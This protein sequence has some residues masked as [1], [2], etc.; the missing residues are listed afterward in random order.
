M[1]CPLCTTTLLNQNGRLSISCQKGFELGRGSVDRTFC[2]LQ[3][4]A[5]SGCKICWDVFGYIKTLP[6]DLKTAGSE[7]WKIAYQLDAEYYRQCEPEV[8]RE[9]GKIG[10]HLRIV[11]DRGQSEE[12]HF[13]LFPLPEWIKPTHIDEIVSEAKEDVS[14]VSWKLRDLARMPDSP[15][16]T[17]DPAVISLAKTWLSKC[18]EDHK[19]CKY[20][21]SEFYP[22]RLLELRNGEPSL[23]ETRDQNLR[24]PYATLS[25]CWGQDDFFTLSEGNLDDLMDTVPVA[26]LPKSFQDAILICKRLDIK[27]LWIDSLCIIQSKEEINNDWLEHA[28]TMADI[29]KN[30]LL[31]ISIDRA[32]NPYEGA[33]AE[34]SPR[35]LD[36]CFALVAT[37]FPENELGYYQICGVLDKFECIE[38]T[39]LSRRAWAFQERYLSPRVLHFGTDRIWWECH[40]VSR[41]EGSTSEDQEIDPDPFFTDNKQMNFLVQKYCSRSLTRPDKDKLVAFAAVAREME[42]AKDDEYVAG[43]FKGEL[44]AALLWSPFQ[45]HTRPAKYQAPSWSWASLNGTDRLHLGPVCH[46]AVAEV[47]EIN[48]KYV[49][50]ENRYGLVSSGSL[51]IKGPMGF[52]LWD[53]PE[54]W[55]GEQIWHSRW[56]DGVLVS[57]IPT[58]HYTGTTLEISCCFD[59]EN[60]RIW[61]KNR[62]C[63]FLL[64]DHMEGLLLAETETKGVYKRIGTGCF[65]ERHRLEDFQER[66]IKLI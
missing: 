45:P 12:R 30:C 53:G 26:K 64:I 51:R 55:G 37:S 44:P 59:T 63:D 47:L 24:H 54:I 65:E 42:K 14:M 57:S 21:N 38:L 15:A 3:E 61:H 60:D 31:N 50:E 46:D 7:L 17:G 20:S 4:S 25:H 36:P 49:D 52:V 5:N 39:P 27:Y 34:R 41:A 9:F 11:W 18:R 6:D 10:L 32:A 35:L 28:R 19:V 22:K 29:Y 62:E 58:T 23:I 43:L 56:D 2:E 16:S 66:E 13:A 33:F 8:R 40:S 1:L 48:L